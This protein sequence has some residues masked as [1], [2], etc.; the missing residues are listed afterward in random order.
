MA[1]EKRGILIE[2]VDMS[3][4]EA[5]L[6]QDGSY[7][8][9]SRDEMIRENRSVENYIRDGLGFSEQEINHLRDEL[10]E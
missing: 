8:D 2:Q 4:M 3:N 6:I 5:F 1:A 9:A 10:L 7:I